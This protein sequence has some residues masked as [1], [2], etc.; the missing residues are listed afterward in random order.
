MQ[1][2]LQA[3]WCNGQPLTTAQVSIFDRGFAYGDGGFTTIYVAQGKPQLWHWHLARLKA[4]A[5][6]LQLVV[7]DWAALT[8]QFFRFTAG[9]QEA[10]AKIVLTRGVGGRGYLPPCQPAD[11][12]FLAFP[13]QRGSNSP[14]QTG[15]L[16]HYFLSP[17]MPTLAGLK[18]LNRLEQVILRQALAQTHWP[19]ALVED[20]TGQ[21]V[22]GVMSNVVYQL[23]DHAAWWTPPIE[24][25]GIRGVYRQALLDQQRLQERPLPRQALAQV[26]ALA[27]INALTGVQEVAQLNDRHLQ[28]GYADALRLDLVC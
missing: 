17:V 28:T 5:D 25:C 24:R 13:Y 12:Y 27:F 3:C 18:T 19:E 23:N 10:A 6:A 4:I 21:I 15:C 1:S 20:E 2:D 11:Y 8:D 9:Y 7:N 22:E 26:Q 14:I 16:E